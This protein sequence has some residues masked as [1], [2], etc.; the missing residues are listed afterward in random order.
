MGALGGSY[1]KVCAEPLCDRRLTRSLVGFSSRAPH[2]GGDCEVHLSI[3][4]ETDF[5]TFVPMPEAFALRGRPAKDRKAGTDRSHAS[6]G[7]GERRA[8]TPRAPRQH[9]CC[10]GDG[11]SGC[12]AFATTPDAPSLVYE[13]PR[14]QVLTASRIHSGIMRVENGG[15]GGVPSRRFPATATCDFRSHQAA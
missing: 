13:T 3:S 10:F 14:A 4:P 1:R 5:S 7:V 8:V 9:G 15:V 6:R 11:A 12:V 2:T